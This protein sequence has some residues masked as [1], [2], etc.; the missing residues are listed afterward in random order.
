M[1]NCTVTNSSATE[2]M[3]IIL[4]DS[5]SAAVGPRVRANMLHPIDIKFIQ[6]R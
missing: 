3:L 2:S 1:A 6:I 4:I 5:G